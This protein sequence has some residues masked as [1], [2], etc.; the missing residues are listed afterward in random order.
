MS[1]DIEAARAIFSRNGLDFPDIPERFLADFRALD[2][3]SWGTS[4]HEYSLYNVDDFV[5]E[6]ALDE[7]PDYCLIGFAGHGVNSWAVHYYLVDGP[8]AVF[9]Q[10]PWGGAYMDAARAATDFKEALAQ[11]VR[12]RAGIG[13]AAVR[14]PPGWRLLVVAS[15]FS[16][17][18]GCGWVRPPDA[19]APGH[20]RRTGDRPLT[21]ALEA[22][23]AV[24]SGT[25]I[26]G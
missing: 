9:L 14:V 4:P 6:V 3:A 5:R 18:A 24:A 7:T 1:S 8:L 12:L 26:I 13:A 22:V 21:A 10:V 16:P 17:A 2:D 23:D 15:G 19:G 11:T 25:L 20:W